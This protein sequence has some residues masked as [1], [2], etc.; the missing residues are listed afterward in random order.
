MAQGADAQQDLAMPLKLLIVDDSELIRSSLRGMVAGLPG[1]TT[2]QMAASLDEAV[3]SARGDPPDLVVLD[4]FL[5]DGVSLGFI[6]ALIGQVP[7]VQIA[8]LTNDIHPVNRTHSLAAGA[9]WFFDKSTEFI[10]LLDVVRQQAAL[11]QPNPQ[12]PA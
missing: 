5:P 9:H 7:G 3:K 10:Q 6:T 11:R 12:R 8:V 2:V 1:S 4:L